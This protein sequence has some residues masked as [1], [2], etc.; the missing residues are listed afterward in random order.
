MPHI[1]FGQTVKNARLE[2]KYS[3]RGLAAEVGVS[4]SYI[5]DIENNRR[6]PSEAV[7]KTLA[8]K[9]NTSM[10]SLMCIAGRLGTRAEDYIK[11]EPLA[12]ALVRELARVEAT[13]DQI[14]EL[15]SEIGGW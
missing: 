15:I 11:Q 10:E 7:I 2:A 3:L 8:G 13:E 4:P 9:L 12:L 6:V 1:T 5:S 14:M